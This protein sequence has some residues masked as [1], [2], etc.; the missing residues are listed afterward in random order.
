M[1][2]TTKSAALWVLDKM[3]GGDEAH[4]LLQRYVMKSL[5]RPSA[6]IPEYVAGYRRHIEAFRSHGLDIE[7]GLLLSF[8]AGWD[9][10]ENLVYYAYGVNRQIAI[11]VEL[12]ARIELVDALAADLARAP[13]EGAAPRQFPSLG[14]DLKSGLLRHYGVDYRAPGDA[15]NTRLPARSVEMIATSDTLEHIPRDA[16]AVIMRECRRIIATN[17]VVSMSVDYSDH[18]SHVDPSITPYNFLSFD[19][20]DWRRHNTASHYQNRMRHKDYVELFETAGFRIASQ[21]VGR[22]PDWLELL[23]AQPIAPEFRHYEPEELAI[24]RGCF[25]LVPDDGR[26]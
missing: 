19:A 24:T 18:F 1:K 26:A 25:T 6:R 23:E 14:S 13:L 10:F 2:W 4:Y 3:P 5:P 20:V 16:L 22:P 17:G 7:K 8:G 12:L 21:V 15:R 11:D 9:L